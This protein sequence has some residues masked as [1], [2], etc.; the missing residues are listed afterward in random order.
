MAHLHRGQDLCVDTADVLL[1]DIYASQ[2]L[3]A[4]LLRHAVHRRQYLIGQCQGSSEYGLSL[5]TYE[6]ASRALSSGA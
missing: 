3:R 1:A 5:A 6:D 2:F 4:Q